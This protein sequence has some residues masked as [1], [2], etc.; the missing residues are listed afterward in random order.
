MYRDMV[1]VIL[2]IDEFAH[3][4][5]RFVPKDYHARNAFGKQRSAITYCLCLVPSFVL[6]IGILSY[7]VTLTEN[8]HESRCD[9]LPWYYV[10]G[11]VKY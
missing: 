6:Y 4:A 5:S 8:S 11:E 3:W 1:F 7:K 2:D 9:F 10:G